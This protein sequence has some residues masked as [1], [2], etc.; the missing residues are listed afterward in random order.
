M[1]FR[2]PTRRPGQYAKKARAFKRGT[3]SDLLVSPL[4]QRPFSSTSVHCPTVKLDPKP[5]Q[6]PRIRPN[7]PFGTADAPTAAVGRRSIL[8]F[9]ASAAKAGARIWPSTEKTQT[10][11]EP[12]NRSGN[13]ARDASCEHTRRRFS[14]THMASCEVTSAGEAAVRTCQHATQKGTRKGAALFRFLGAAFFFFS[15][16]K[17]TKNKNQ[18]QRAHHLPRSRPGVGCFCYCLVGEA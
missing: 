16:Q 5:F 13:G 15:N 7:A 3:A 4:K 8:A 6:T 18:N 1:S 14:V 12:Q 2:K 9:I 17:P 10:W 11:A